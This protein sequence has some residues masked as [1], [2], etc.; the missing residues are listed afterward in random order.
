M[1]DLRDAISGVLREPPEIDFRFCRLGRHEAV[2]DAIAERFLTNG[3]RDLNQVWLHECFHDITHTCQPPDIFAELLKRLSNDEPY[4]F[5]VSEENGK[6]WVAQ[7]TGAAIIKVIGE[8]SCFEYYII[9]RQMTR[10]LCES[11]HNMLIEAR[12]KDQ[13]DPLSIP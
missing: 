8:M 3:R 12:A 1:K 13:S 10:I 11:H 2:L 4:W 6:Y 5:L 7:G 9:D